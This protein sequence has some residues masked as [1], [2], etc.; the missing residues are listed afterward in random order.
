MTVRR[1]CTAAVLALALVPGLRAAE[2]APSKPTPVVLRGTVVGPASEKAPSG[3]PIAKAKVAVVVTDPQV[4]SRRAGESI[5]PVRAETAA[6]GTFAVPGL[7]G[8]TFTVRVQAPG[9]APFEVQDV[10]A[11]AVLKVRLAQGLSIEGRVLDA[12][13]R[14]PVPGVSVVGRTRASRGMP[15]EM[16]PQAVTDAEG[17]F[18]L[19]DL[20]PG[21]VSVEARGATWARATEDA[22]AVPQ[23]GPLE[24]VVR[25]GG[26]LAGRVLDMEGKPVEG[27]TVRVEPA[28]LERL[29]DVLRQQPVRTDAKGAF[30]FEGL[31]AGDTYRISAS[32]KGFSR[33]SAGPFPIK[34]GTVKEDVE[35]KLD[36]SAA[37]RVRLVDQDGKPV[38]ALEVAVYPESDARGPRGGSTNDV[39]DDQIAAEGDGRFRI[40]GLPVGKAAV[41][42]LPDG[43]ASIERKDLKL[44]PGKTGELGTLTVREGRVLRG[45]VLDGNG[46]PVEGATVR[47]FWMAD[48]R[49]KSRQAESGGDGRFRM[50]GLSEGALQALM[51]SAKGFASKTENGVPTDQE[52]EIALE[53]AGAIVGRVLLEDTRDPVPAKVEATPEAR[54]ETMSGMRFQFGFNEDVFADASG[55]FRVENLA[56]GK[57]TLIATLPGKAPARVAGLEVRSEDVA[58]AGTVLLKEGLALHGRVLDAKDDSPIPGAT[59]SVDEPQG[60]MRFSLGEVSAHATLT[61]AQGGFDVT[62]LESK[63][64]DVSVAH[65]E[66]ARAAARAEAKEDAPEVVV[67]L[68]RGG[69]LTGTVRD[70]QKLPVPNA[71]IMVMQGMGGTPQST[72]TG[73]DGV[74]KLERLTPGSYRVLRLPEGGRIAITI[75]PGMKMVDVEE[76]EVTVLDFDDAAKITLSGRVLRGDRPIPGAMLMFFAGDGTVGTATDMRTA[77]AESDGRFQVG[78]DQAGL[79]TVVVQGMEHMMSRASVKIQVPDQSQVTQDVVVSGGGITGVVTGPD[80]APVTNAVVR[81]NPDPP[82]QQPRIGGSGAQT[83]QDGSYTI[84]GL[85]PGTY[86][87]RAMAPGKKPAE[88]TATVGDDG[89]TARVDLRLEPGRSL[90]GR[91]VDPRGNGLQGATVLAAPAGST[92]FDSSMMGTTDVNGAFEI[93]APSD[94]LIDVAAIPGGYAPALVQNVTPSDD[95]DG[96]GVRLEA[97]PGGRIR[98]HVV[99][100]DGRGRSG[101]QLRVRP[102]P[103]FLGSLSFRQAAVPPT[104]GQGFA[105]A[106]LL[107]PATYAVSLEN[108][109][110]VAP[111]T[112]AVSEGALVEPTLTVP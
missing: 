40:S 67:R 77:N 84:D 62:G 59:V 12:A 55:N 47:G 36:P 57:Y 102:Q 66:Y 106:D 26:R 10:G 78:L 2:K 100:A 103:E 32:K 72:A 98:V 7:A 61:D 112:V 91:V 44:E 18:R 109:P 82:P 49:F 58:D 28:A 105:T 104:D 23:R 101:V 65:P 97:S 81:A 56:P 64:Y 8:K 21:V 50:S 90:R 69:T 85:E 34:A 74:Y 45:R 17:R 30:S 79:Y 1:I 31:Q 99:G 13:S 71:S 14:K 22:V 80:N 53:R 27:V 4:L 9:F 3:A 42:L 107:R 25:P 96:P 51:V 108:H 92:A 48:G 76:G 52:A 94:G 19:A 73:E 20:A 70:A 5:P 46:G 41:E 16:L 39:P 37:L 11:G 35:L 87:V 38:S 54:A 15:E 63:T 83:R 43:Y 110:E 93:I 88:A 24:L 75:G 68:S 86:K 95:P 111:V 89:T 29:R 33:A 60:G 6:D